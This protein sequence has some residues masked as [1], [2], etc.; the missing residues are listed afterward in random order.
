MHPF[1]KSYLSLCLGLDKVRNRE[2]YR[3]PFDQPR[4]DQGMKKPTNHLV[5]LSNG[6]CLA[7]DWV[8]LTKPTKPTSSRPLLM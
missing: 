5:T 4:K 3:S 7:D 2:R 8:S 6:A 1:V